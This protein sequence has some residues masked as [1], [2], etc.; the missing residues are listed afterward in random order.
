MPL[1]FFISPVTSRFGGKIIVTGG[2]S[3]VTQV[4]GG[5]TGAEGADFLF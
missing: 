2:T 1:Y 5:E 3:P 4:L